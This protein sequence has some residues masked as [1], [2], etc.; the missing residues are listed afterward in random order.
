M[1]ALE[2]VSAPTWEEQLN[3]IA[4]LGVGLGYD[5]NAGGLNYRDLF[6]C[7]GRQI[8]YLE[9]HPIYRRQILDEIHES[10]GYEVPFILHYNDLG[11]CDPSLEVEDHAEIINGLCEMMSPPWFVEDFGYWSLDG[12]PFYSFMPPVLTEDSLETTC[13]NMLALQKKVKVPYLPENP[14]FMF[15]VGPMH[16]LEFAGELSRRT[17]CALLL[18]VGHLFSFQVVK[19]REPLEDLHLLPLDR[20]YEIHIA[21]GDVVRSRSGYRYFDDNHS[22]PISPVVL[23]MLAEILPKAT[24]LRALTVEVDFNQAAKSVVDPLATAV[25]NFQKVRSLAE[26]RWANGAW[27]GN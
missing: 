9:S 12:R 24:N 2:D 26:R 10:V 22:R 5:I 11:I 15:A 18:D 27:S 16:I 3:S 14:A 13:R 23:D 7:L 19:G 8:N 17:G 21:G 4:P 6:G 25:E 20:V 1:E